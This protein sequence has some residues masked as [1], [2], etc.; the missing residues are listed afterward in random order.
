MK[1]KNNKAP[2]V[3][4]GLG[5]TG[6]SIARAL[7]REGIKVIGLSPK[8]LPESYSRF[9]TYVKEPPNNSENERL[10]FFVNLGQKLKTRAVLLPT[11][12][13]NVMFISRYRE[14]L[15]KHFHYFLPA[16]VLLKAITSKTIF[17]KLAEE[18]N[19]S[20]PAS[21]Q[22]SKQ[23]DI[24]Q[25]PETFFPC[26][27]KPDSQELW[28]SQKAKKIGIRGLKALPV[29]TKNEL[30]SQ[31][32]RLR[33]IGSGLM[34]Q[35]MVVGPD[36]NH[37]DYHALKDSKGQIL[38]EFVGKKIRLTP[39]H[40]GMGCYVESVK[41]DEIIKEGRKI[42]RLLNY[43]GMANINFK[44][45]VRD[46]RLYFFELNPRFSFWTG[47]D[48]AC[49][50][51]F[52]YYYYKL[53]LGEHIVPKKEYLV[54]KKWINLSRDVRGIRTF[55]KD[56]SVSWHEWIKSL[57]TTDVGAIYASDDPLPAIMLTLQLFKRLVSRKI[58][59]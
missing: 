50:V 49:G 9:V 17:I 27:V 24:N 52:P 38:G 34:V 22:I 46:G 29:M 33:E 43:E 11:G 59:I 6:L 51:N 31:Y 18:L 42:L 41:S 16:H 48:V 36:E 55:L 15:Q 8:R 3:V 25:I 23:S 20:L 57:L 39:P 19:I 4:I 54:G 26:V 1:N 28:W 56:G 13:S 37:L 32:R 44:K 7:G 47:L 30:Y 14:T 40:F 2:A 58:H 35:K 5:V 53:C 21:I 12:D 10:D 45:D